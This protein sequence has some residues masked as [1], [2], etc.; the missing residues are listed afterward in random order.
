MSSTKEKLLAVFGYLI[1][2][3]FPVPL[4]TIV[5]IQVYYMLFRGESIFLD[6]HQR[7]N[8]NFQISCQLYVLV[9]FVLYFIL[10]KV[11]PLL[12]DI[13]VAFNILF[14]IATFG[15]IVFFSLFWLVTMIVAIIRA[16]LGKPF[17]FPL[18][19]RFVK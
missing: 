9:A 1:P 5:A 3:F 14:G 18:T 6:K 12:P 11:A 17:R 15:F 8:V 16:A 10:F 19:I 4:L 7:E 2:I 13:A